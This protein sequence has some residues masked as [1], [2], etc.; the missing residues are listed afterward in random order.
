MTVQPEKIE[1]VK[2]FVDQV[3]NANAEFAD[4]WMKNTFLHWDFWVSISLSILPWLLWAYFRKKE[5]QGRLLLAG[6]L[7]II[8]STWFDFL[9]VITG[10]WFYTGKVIPTI[11]TYIPWDFCILP[12]I[13]M[14]TIQTKPSIRPWKKGILFSAGA[15]FIGEPIFKWLGF[16]VDVNWNELYSFPIYFIIYLL[17]DRMTKVKGFQPL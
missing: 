14:L 10:L 7:M 6:L 16:Y 9:G 2:K 11:P 1:E 4:Y 12:V 5:S 17:C 13:V 15:S 3:V 8:V